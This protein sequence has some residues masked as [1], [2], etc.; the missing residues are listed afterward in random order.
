M[1]VHPIDV[2]KTRMQLSGEKGA[3]RVHKTAFHA[4]YNVAKAEG[5]TALYKGLTAAILRQWTYGTV[6]FGLFETM[7]EKARPEWRKELWANVGMGMIAGACGAVAG[8]PADLS[9][10][11]MASDG[12]LPVAER[13][14]Y[15]NVFNALYRISKEEGIPSLWKG[16]QPTIIRAVVLN[17]AQL[18]GYSYI[19]E[20]L[21]TTPYFKEDLKTHFSAS[22]LSGF[23]CSV[24]S[25]PVD[26][27][28]TR[29]QS[30]KPVN[31]VLPYKGMVDCARIV[32]QY[33]GLWAFWKGFTPY[34]LRLGPQTVLSFI[35]L[36][37]LKLRIPF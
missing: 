3:Q 12:R 24:L 8:T 27:M 31:G 2:I 16:G 34:Y 4:I 32:Y 14:G 35:I 36:E 22:M 11:R 25:L 9:L 20:F 7:K 15:T 30:M 17:A 1:I 26:I 29:L 13:R 5:P 19:K 37:Q 28:K 18:G 33:E 6:R 10:I 21:L 23:L